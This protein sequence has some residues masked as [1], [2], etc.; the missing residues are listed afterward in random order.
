MKRPGAATLAALIGGA[1]IAREAVRHS[2]RM[3]LQE[4]TIIVTGGVR[5]LGLAISRQLVRHGAKLA[6]CSRNRDQVERAQ[7]ELAA[8]GGDV[9]AV[10]CDITKDTDVQEFLDRVHSH[11]GAVDA[12]INN[13]GVISVAPMQD[14]TLV[15]YQSAMDT[16]FWAPLKLTL[17]VLPDMKRHRRGRIVNIASF[18]GLVSV[19]HL[20]PYS[21]SKFALVGLSQ[22]LR[23]ELLHDGVYVTTVCPGLIRTGSPRNVP[24]KGHREL[25]YA[26][27][28]LGDVTPII[29]VNPDR[30]AKK[31]VDAMVHGDAEVIAPWLFRIPAMANAISPT[32]TSGLLAMINNLLPGPAGNTESQP[33]YALQSSSHLPA[34]AQKSADAAAE[35]YNEL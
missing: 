1:W 19:P 33:G 17:A 23:S 16:H 3:N 10:P 12:L 30:L 20:V 6:I 7:I 13:A 14:N 18:G 15:D 26:W 29:S 4:K 32:L 11:F 28:T 24:F 35:K 8:A 21:A 31:I 2:R 27:F 9:L 5:G 25:E 34:W 22:G